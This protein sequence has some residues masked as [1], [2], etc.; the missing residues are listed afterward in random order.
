MITPDFREYHQDLISD[1]ID[2]MTAEAKLQYGMIHLREALRNMRTSRFADAVAK[3]SEFH[4]S[5]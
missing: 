3:V 4:A 5:A 1:K 2:M